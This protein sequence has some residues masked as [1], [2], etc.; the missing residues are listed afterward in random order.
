VTRNSNYGIQ[1]SHPSTPLG[2]L[3]QSA[4]VLV[5]GGEKTKKKRR[6][7]GLPLPFLRFPSGRVD[8]DVE[9]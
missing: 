2:F 9:V 4:L 5:A 6:E 3:E 7:T 8:E 1:T